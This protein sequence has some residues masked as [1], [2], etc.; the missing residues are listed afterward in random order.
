MYIIKPKRSNHP[1][2]KIKGGLKLEKIIS[3][4]GDNC[5]EILEKPEVIPPTDEAYVYQSD[6]AKSIGMKKW[7]QHD[8]LETYFS[9]FGNDMDNK[10]RQNGVQFESGDNAFLQ[11]DCCSNNGEVWS[12]SDTSDD[13]TVVSDAVPVA[14]TSS[15]S[16]CQYENISANKTDQVFSEIF[17]QIEEIKQI[18]SKLVAEDQPED[19]SAGED[20]EPGE[21]EIPE[22]LDNRHPRDTPTDDLD[23]SNFDFE[24]LTKPLEEN[25]NENQKEYKR[26]CAWTKIIPNAF[27]VRSLDTTSLVLRGQQLGPRGIKTLCA[28]LISN[29]SVTDIEISE[30]VIDLRTMGH[31]SEMYQE[32][33][34]INS[35]DFSDNRMGRLPV[36]VLLDTL[37]M[38]DR[39]TSLSLSGNALKDTD[40]DIFEAY[41]TSTEALQDLDISYN[42]FSLVAGKVL[43]EAFGKNSSIENLSIRWN[44]LNFRGAISFIAGVLNS[45]SIA[46]LD[47]AWNGLGV[48]SVATLCRMIKKNTVLEELDISSNR[49][50]FKGLTD[51]LTA[52]KHNTGLRNLHMGD[53]VLSPT[54]AHEL[55]KN[56][57]AVRGDISLKNLSLGRQTINIGTV[58]LVNSLLDDKDV[59]VTH[60]L[61]YGHKMNSDAEELASLNPVTLLLEFGRLLQMTIEEL[62]VYIDA[63][64]GGTL[65]RDEIRE[66]MFEFDIPLPERSLDILIRKMDSDG[67]GEIALSDLQSANDSDEINRIKAKMRGRCMTGV[68]NVETE[69][70]R[71]RKILK[72]LL[73]ESEKKKERTNENT[74]KISEGSESVSIQHSHAS[75]AP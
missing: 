40:G 65:S 42:C 10:R 55:L 58:T 64:G 37:T 33:Q 56:L 6:F 13:V 34:F 69:R 8:E 57:L 67:D 5:V 31:I 32:N 63:D 52:L 49:I 22:Q 53:N 51:F 60:G 43:G 35:L 26:Q 23:L 12:V 20:I 46:F 25:L 30:D 29:C 19:G 21:E 61:V 59:M 50:N 75:H 3:D 36:K 27:V 47:L 62:F 66:G 1:P 38:Q 2:R 41:I 74:R 45:S 54:D 72:R 28:A 24:H 68:A 44:H 7:N 39:V 17:E 18:D 73:A 11:Q 71:C 48:E 16:L 70:I 14:S 4:E 9:G 15:S